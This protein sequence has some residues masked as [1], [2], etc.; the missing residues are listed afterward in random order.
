MLAGGG[1]KA[2]F[3]YGASDRTG[4]MPAGSPVTPG[5]II[6]TLYHLFGI[7]H[8]QEIRDQLQRRFPIVRRGEVVSEL[9]A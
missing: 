8:H 1:I 9:L 4:S 3:V 2:G 7:D 6:A 5:D